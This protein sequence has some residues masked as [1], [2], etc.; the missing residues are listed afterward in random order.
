ME[1]KPSN[2]KS[3]FFKKEGFY[4]VLFLC[5]CIVAAIAAIS[6]KSN[7]HVKKEPIENKV[8]ENK[9][10]KDSAKAIEGNSKSYNNALEVKKE[11]N[12]ENEK[13]K[14]NEK[15]TAQVSKAESNSFI[16]P[17]EGTLA[18]VYSEDPVFW[19]STS[20]YRA[21]L[22][23]D[24]KAKLNSPVCSIADGKVEDIV[25][26]SQDGVK[27]TVNHQNGIKSV[28]ANLDPKVKVT[29]GQQIKQGCL[30]GNVGKTTLRAAYEKYGD[31]LHFA[32]MKG[33]KYINPSKHIKY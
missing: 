14:Q 18:R 4:V 24:I 32:M 19:S 16:K 30:I 2:K 5:L 13:S 6:V 9:K 3:N 10:E 25:T 28:Y 17:V 29:K 8:V 20:S 23:L 27:V 7:S 22:G 11:E 21:N 12:K 1:K 33:N 15:E 31:H 26:S